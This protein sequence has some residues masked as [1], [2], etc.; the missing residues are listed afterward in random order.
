MTCLS[1]G[2]SGWLRRSVPHLA[3]PGS[4]VT[5]A[6]VCPTCHGKGKVPNSGNLFAQDSTKEKNPEFSS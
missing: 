6:K 2:G 3:V 5:V 1:C 4:M